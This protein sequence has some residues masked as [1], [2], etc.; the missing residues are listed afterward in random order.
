MAFLY[1]KSESAPDFL[2]PCSIYYVT[3][4]SLRTGNEPITV[5]IIQRLDSSKLGGLQQSLLCWVRSLK[6]DGRRHGVD[7]QYSGAVT[8]E[9]PYLVTFKSTL[10][11]VYKS[12]AP[13]RSGLPWLQNLPMFQLRDKAIRNNLHLTLFLN[14]LASGWICRV[15]LKRDFKDLVRRIMF[16]S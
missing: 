15:V 3:R 4:H 9:P 16:D 11:C 1:D 5:N 10:I 13:S 7:K 2:S 6:P 8:R 14:A 12:L